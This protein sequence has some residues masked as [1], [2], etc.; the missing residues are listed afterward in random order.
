MRYNF[1]LTFLAVVIGFSS[2]SN[3]KTP[4][5]I[6]RELI[7]GTPE[8]SSGRL[9]PD[10]E[11]LAF[12]R[13]YNGI[14]NIW[15][16][17]RDASF[18]M[19]LPVTS[20]TTR[21]IRG[22][23]WSGDGKY[24]LYVQDN[25]GDENYNVYA[26]NPSEA[27]EDVL[28][29]A[30]NLT[31]LSHV[32]VQIHHISRIDHDLMFVGLNDRDKVWHDLYSLKIST[33][34]LALLKKNTNR[35]ISWVFDHNDNLRL[36]QRSSVDGTRELWRMDDGMQKVLYTST[37]FETAYPLQFTKDNCNFYFVSNAEDGTDFTQLY[38]MNI[39]TGEL[40]FIE[41]DPEQKADFGKL[42]LS[43]KTFE[44]LY[45][46]YA[47]AFNRRYFKDVN[48]ENHYNA[49]ANKFKGKEVNIYNAT[50]DE[51][52]WLVSVWSDTN[53]SNIYI[54]DMETGELS[55]QYNPRS[56]L[57][58]EFLSKMRSITYPSSDGL[59]IQAYLTLP[60]GYGDTDLPL[61]VLP[62]GGPWARDWWGYDKYVQFLANRGYAVLQPNFRG[63]K[64]FGKK[65]LNAGNGEWGNLM[66]DDITWGVKHLIDKGIVDKDRVGIF[67]ISYGG[68]AALAG[69]AFTPEVYACGIS[70]VGPSNLI[71]LLN[72]IPPYWEA[73]RISFYHRIGNPT[74]PEGL[75]KIQ[76]QSPLFSADKIAAPLLVVQ[77]QNDPR[78]KKAESDQIVVALRNRGFDVE[79]INAPDEGHGFVRPVNRMA[80]VATMEKFLATHLG[81][82]YQ[83]EIPEPIKNRL[84]EI[85]V[86]VSTVTLEEK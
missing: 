12:L 60:N 11:F 9:S 81:G 56:T 62:H 47:D 68:Y 24:I 59:E 10:G 84:K 13:P 66:Q 72:S 36:A 31:N 15:I 63:S 39:E 27:K 40:K 20:E 71:T 33:G 41:S 6:D 32:R 17:P 19:A 5:I 42:V 83:S 58:T 74:T 29:E 46:Y 77:G 85:T 14:Q 22:Y 64:G 44:P 50:T 75:A 21:P 52:Y 57:P 3:S 69:L 53:P 2:C 16:K 48:F 54:Y 45:T 70:F 55:F 26:V 18:D 23:F 34:E 65:F 38:S 28:P 25:A 61:V 43:Q 67:G 82:R 86:D 30:R 78:V 35:Y 1:L 73:I 79:Y 49:L 51:R 7:F 80:F 4:P 8:I 76:Q 37:M